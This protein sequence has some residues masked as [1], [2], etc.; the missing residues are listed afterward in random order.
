MI[1]DDIEIFNQLFAVIF[2]GIDDNHDAFTLE[3][4]IGGGASTGW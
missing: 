4:V 1:Q 2:S 3:I